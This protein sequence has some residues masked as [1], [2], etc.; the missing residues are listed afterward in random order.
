M[1]CKDA[2]SVEFNSSGVPWLASADTLQHA[3]QSSRC[4]C[5]CSGLLGGEGEIII[6]QKLSPG[7]PQPLLQPWGHSTAAMDLCQVGTL[8]L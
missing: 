6:C 4:S 7:P 2:E 3:E 8:H 5:C 1:D